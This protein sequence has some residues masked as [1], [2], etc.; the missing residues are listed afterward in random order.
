MNCFQVSLTGYINNRNNSTLTTLHC[1]LTKDMR[2]SKRNSNR[3]NS[4][5]SLQNRHDSLSI[6]NT[7]IEFVELEAVVEKS[8]STQLH[9]QFHSMFSF[10]ASD[11]RAKMPPCTDTTEAESA[12]ALKYIL[13]C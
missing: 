11:D 10:L 7:M 8:T 3:A 13:V 6:S 5:F 9:F 4:F 1:L 2:N 12:E